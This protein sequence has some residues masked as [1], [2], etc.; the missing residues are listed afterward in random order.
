VICDSSVVPALPLINQAIAK[1]GSELWISSKEGSPVV[2]GGVSLV[3]DHGPCFF[4]A[5]A[6]A[7]RL[8]RDLRKGAQRLALCEL[9]NSDLTGPA[10]KF[11]AF[12]GPE[13]P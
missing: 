1:G 2:A 13:G 11:M 9:A 5:L 10:V 4:A 6:D 3:A 12:Q 7:P 8:V